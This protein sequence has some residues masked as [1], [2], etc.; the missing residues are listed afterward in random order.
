MSPELRTNTSSQTTDSLRTSRGLFDPKQRSVGIRLLQRW[1]GIP[2][3]EKI[4]ER[5]SNQLGQGSIFQSVLDVLDVK[6]TISAPYAERIPK[7]GAVV[8]VANHP[9]GI[10][11]GVMLGA[12]LEQARPDVRI[13]ANALLGQFPLIA[14]RLI[15][16]DPF[17]GGSATRSNR[18]GLR[19]ALQWLKNDGMLV[20]FP[21]GEVASFDIRRRSVADPAWNRTVARLIAMAKAPV[22][23]IF[24]EGRNGLAFQMAGLLHPRLR[25]A[26]LP[27]ELL[28][29]TGRTFVIRAG[30][31]VSFKKIES[32]ETDA[33]R[34]E[35]LRRK[36]YVLAEHHEP[37]PALPFLLIPGRPPAPVQK[38][39]P[40]A[41]VEPT[42]PGLMESEIAALP[43]ES[44]LDEQSD[45]AVYLAEANRVPNIVRE[46]GRLRELTF[47]ETGEG[48][49]KSIDLDEFDT[50][51]L[52]LFLWNRTAREVVGAYRLGQSDLI[53]RN[54]GEKGF[55]TG[56]LFAYHRGFLERINPAL[57][58]GRSF[59]RR[60]YQRS[61]APLLLLWR[62]IGAYV[63]SNPRYK[64][65]FGP[66]SISNEYHPN[67]RQLIVHFLKEYCRA[68]DLARFVRARSPLRTR[69]IQGWDSDG[70]NSVAWDIEDLSAFIAD[71]ET[72]QKG[73]PILLK[74]YL[75]LGGK[76]LGFNVDS[77][78][79][80]ALDGLIVVD[81]VKTDP[82]LLERYMGKEGAVAFLAYHSARLAQ[83]R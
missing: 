67:S 70:E 36:T 71:I 56:T 58:M 53:L 1:L 83:I 66:V 82:R 3:L 21:A 75:R 76:L 23:P 48:T 30:N 11:D 68:E 22:V 19:E 25:T 41:L 2:A 54:F 80:N 6:W 59:V 62:G 60:E 34:I 63:R 57:E 35:F 77:N 69:P 15:L 13:M 49:G 74:Q 31:S 9:F 65:L 7:T 38:T 79:S 73:V 72:D 29:K 37:K 27:R 78:F 51:Y 50:Y 40:Q 55:Y 10:I 28:N 8:V 26:L 24:L 52:H 39:I 5:A 20:V 42:D 81:L 14:E 46:I 18:H 61:Y 12:M 16:V 45:T 44:L 64:I 32:F 17:G 47:R 43:L 4:Y 33:E